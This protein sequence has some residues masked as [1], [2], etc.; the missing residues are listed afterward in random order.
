MSYYQ[1]FVINQSNLHLPNGGEREG[2]G[3]IGRVTCSF[4][5]GR[6]GWVWEREGAEVIGRNHCRSNF[7]WYIWTAFRHQPPP[8]LPRRGGTDTIGYIIVIYRCLIIK[9][10]SLTR[11]T[12]TNLSLTIRSNL[13]LPNGG[14]WE[15]A[16]VHWQG[17]L[18]LPFG[19]VRMG[20]RTRGGWSDWQESLSE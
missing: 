3:V 7:S 18:F 20:L 19:K 14:E 4:P 2:A 13:H 11:V 15:G 10:L 17:N 5:W 1:T 16:E 8:N 6:L 12:C 9:H